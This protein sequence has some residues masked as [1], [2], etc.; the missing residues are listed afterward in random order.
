LYASQRSDGA[1]PGAW[2]VYLIYGTMFGVRGLLAAGTP[3]FHPSIRKA[4]RWLLARQRP[5]GGWGEHHSG[6]LTGVYKEHS[7]SQIIQTAWALLTLIEAR[8]PDWAA[9]E[10]GA[11]YLARRQDARGQWPAQDM[12]G[13]F[14]RTALLDYTLYRAYF[15]LWALGLY[16]ARC[17]ERAA[18]APP[19]PQALRAGA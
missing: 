2:G 12:A 19:T 16:Q 14:F 18:F 13:V 3:V 9:I 1:W 5:D 10:R 17:A 7:E 8:E 11:A 15:P 4:C 6:C